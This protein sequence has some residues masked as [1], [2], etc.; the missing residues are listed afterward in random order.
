MNRKHLIRCLIAAMVFLAAV[1][2]GAATIGFELDFEYSGGDEPAGPPPWLV[3]TFEDKGPNQ[4]MLTFDTFGLVANEFVTSLFFN[5]DPA[6][7]AEFL[8]FSFYDGTGLEATVSLGN[9]AQD[10]GGDA[11]KGFDIQFSWSEAQGNRFIAD[12]FIIYMITYF[13]PS[14]PG[15]A[16]SASS[17]N[18]F[19]QGGFLSAAK[20][21]G[22]SPNDGSGWIA[23]VPIPASASLFT[24]GI[25]GLAAIR[26]LFKKMG[27]N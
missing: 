1:P 17:F 15:D 4:V 3:A 9:D 14:N 6:L 7:N 22:I 27:T 8:S 25:L 5:L 11:G 26:K 21:Q 2:A 24:S 20:I 23:A 18:F 16:V 10:A 12:K 19:N 13:D